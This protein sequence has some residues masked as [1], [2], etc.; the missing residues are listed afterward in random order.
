MRTASPRLKQR[1]TRD[2]LTAVL[3]VGA[4]LGPAGLLSAGAVTASAASAIPASPSSAALRTA[5]R[6]DLSRYLTTR[7]TAEHVSAVSLRV[8]F[9]GSRHPIDLAIGTTRYHG[10]PAVSD[11]ALWQIGSNTK[12]FTSVILLKLE[13]EGKLSINDQIGKWLPQYPA[14]RPTPAQRP[15]PPGCRPG[16]SSNQARRH[17]WASPCPVSP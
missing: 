2:R 9:R 3:A 7:R 1:H 14:W 4:L 12:A 10:G 5:L 13:A 11:R 8:T 6:H 17:C 15:M 16:T